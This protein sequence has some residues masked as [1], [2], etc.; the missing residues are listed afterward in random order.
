MIAIVRSKAGEGKYTSVRVSNKA[1]WCARRVYSVTF[2][3]TT[4]CLDRTL[5]ALSSSYL[6][7][8]ADI[9]GLHHEFSLSA[10]VYTTFQDRHPTSPQ[11][12]SPG[13]PA[14]SIFCHSST[15][16]NNLSS[17]HPSSNPLLY[18]AQAPM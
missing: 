15:I 10:S 1:R 6:Y 17:S 16:P 2:N 7:A 3:S 18:A 13:F 11:P 8:H 4:M 5:T 14:L 12:R 9:V